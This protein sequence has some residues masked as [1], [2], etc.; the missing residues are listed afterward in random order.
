MPQ[1]RRPTAADAAKTTIAPEDASPT[2]GAADASFAATPADDDPQA[3]RA[4]IR[5]LE[6]QVPT[7]TGAGED[8]AS[9]G[10]GAYLV[11][12][13]G[14]S[15]VSPRNPAVVELGMQGRVVEIGDAE[16]Q[17]LLMLGAIRA[18]DETDVAT[19][20]GR[21][22][23]LAAAEAEMQTGPA[24]NPYGG[25]VAGSTSL[26]QHAAD[27]I[28]LARKSGAIFDPTLPPPPA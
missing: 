11:T 18:A 28:A 13:V 19:E 21:S 9:E 5:E 14:A 22:L 15:F 4:R 25:M 12:A 20:Q 2:A 17:R 3:L 7:G 1:A 8:T 10:T 6:A 24:R 26:E 23:R 16:A 27:Q